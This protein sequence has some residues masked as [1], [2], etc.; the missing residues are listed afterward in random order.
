M[1]SKEGMCDTSENDIDIKDENDVE[2]L[3][4]VQVSRGIERSRY[5]DYDISCTERGGTRL[6]YVVGASP[7]GCCMGSCR[8][9]LGPGRS[10]MFVPKPVR[11]Y[12]YSE[13]RW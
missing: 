10:L 7:K 6:R 8:L 5:D 13:V 4:T 9:A 2:N 1:F 11:S 12:N 3:C